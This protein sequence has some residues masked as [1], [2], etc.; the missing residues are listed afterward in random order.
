MPMLTA[1]PCCCPDMTLA[2][3]RCLNQSLPT[4]SHNLQETLI[5]LTP[6]THQP[7][8]LLLLIKI[9]FSESGLILCAQNLVSGLFP[10][11]SFGAFIS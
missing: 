6:F 10:S 3:P 2:C 7:S 8:I 9:H 11:Q 1:W 5:H 4:K